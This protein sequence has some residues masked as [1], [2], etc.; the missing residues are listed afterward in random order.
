[1]MGGA[2]FVAGLTITYIDIG[3]LLIYMPHLI[4]G[5]AIV[6]L[7]TAAFLISRNIRASETQWRTAHLIIGILIVS[8]YFIQAFLGLGILL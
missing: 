1:M 2:G 7:I 8:L 5:I 6:S 4:N 3:R